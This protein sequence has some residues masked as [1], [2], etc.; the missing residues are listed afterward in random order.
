MAIAIRNDKSQY[1]RDVILHSSKLLET[2]LRG[3]LP[4]TMIVVYAPQAHRPGKEREDFHNQL[5][6][7]IMKAPEQ[8]P[9]LI[10]EDFNPRLQEPD[11][12]EEE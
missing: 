2:Q 4:M 9:Y 12:E 11:N 3:T 8:E 6:Q 1:I 5:I 7:A 10:M